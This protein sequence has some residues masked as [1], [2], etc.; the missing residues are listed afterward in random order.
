MKPSKTAAFDLRRPAALLICL[1]VALTALAP[2][3]ACARAEAKIV[4]VGWYESPF[5]ITD[6]HGRRSG[7]AYEYQRKIAAYTG[8]RYEYVEGSWPDLM[9]M[10]VDGEIDLMSDVSYTPE[11]AE[12][13]LFPD[14]PMSAEEYYLFID[15]NNAEI[16]PADY[17]TL[18][19]KT[20]AAY[21]GSYQIGLYNEWAK[22]HGV[23]AEVLE[24]TDSVEDILQMLADGKIDVYLALD[25]YG[26][27]ETTIPVSLVGSS[28]F[29]FAVNRD[30]PDLLSELNVA[31]SR[32]RDE[33]RYYNQ[34][35]YE[36][37]NRT[38][39]ANL[40]LTAREADWLE[41]HGPIR[42]GYQDNYMA[43]CDEDEN[44]E[45]SGTLKDYLA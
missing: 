19:G 38:S 5:N 41:T 10:L 1:F 4:R 7:Y 13:M 30:R 37:Y 2:L 27:P 9:Q 18:N 43:F 40:S 12:A 3:A 32:I 26:N 21:K 8:W 24:L 17:S 44:G 45:L 15:R 11:R 23:E 20:I 39:N 6:R 29:Y 22:A 33:N 16:D 42:V 14:L 25:S 34:D 28:D 36:K 35:M 31:M